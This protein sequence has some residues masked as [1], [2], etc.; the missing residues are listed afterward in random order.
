MGI[1]HRLWATAAD[2]VLPPAVSRRLARRIRM[3]TPI[4][5][6][7]KEVLAGNAR[8]QNAYPSR[9]C[10]V[11][12]NGPSLAGT[13]LEPLR[14]DITI[15][16]NHFNRD[17]ASKEFDP[18]I[19]CAAE[20]AGFYS[21]A[22]GIAYLRDLVS[23]YKSTVHVFPIEMLGVFDQNA[24][25]PRERLILV[26]QDGRLAEDFDRIDLTGV[27]PGT[28]DT[29]ILAVS[30]AIAMGCNPIVLL[31]LDY[32][33]LVRGPMAHSYGDAAEPEP[34]ASEEV[35][36]AELPYLTKIELTA[37]RWRSH[38]ALQRI[39]ARSGQVILNATPGSYLDVYPRTS[40]SEVLGAD[41]GPG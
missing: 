34:P 22:E 36:Y 13:D 15:V 7:Q 26:R 35:P 9:R 11:I 8:L 24:I 20:P 17:P 32:G 19:H 29:S 1:K 30:V 33:W 3:L 21:G 39:A 6:K 38:A 37:P 40:L 27:I 18:T 25:V 14:R 4:P 41:E 16:M 28:H 10:F 5:A 23:G 2:W 31:G 12:G